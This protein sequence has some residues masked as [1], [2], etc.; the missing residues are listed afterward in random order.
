MMG[1]IGKDSPRLPVG[2]EYFELDMMED[3][4]TPLRSVEES[5]TCPKSVRLLSGLCRPGGG[6]KVSIWG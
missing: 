1:G 3:K 4:T 6:A 5:E 2:V